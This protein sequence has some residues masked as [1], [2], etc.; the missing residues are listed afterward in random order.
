MTLQ[1]VCRIVVRRILRK[2]IQMEYPLLSPGASAK[3]RP[4][5][6]R[7]PR[8]CERR[9]RINFIPMQAGLMI[10]GQFPPM[11]SDEENAD[12]GLGTDDD[13]HNAVMS[14]GEGDRDNDS[15][16]SDPA[17]LRPMFWRSPPNFLR[18]D[19]A[20]EEDMA[21][22]VEPDEDREVRMENGVA[23]KDRE[24]Q[25]SDSDEE[26]GAA[27]AVDSP[28][29]DKV[30][31]NTASEAIVIQTSEPSS[32]NGYSASYSSSGIGTCSSL[33]AESESGNSTD[34][35]S[36]EDLPKNGTLAAAATRDTVFDDDAFGIDL[37]SVSALK[38][39]CQA[40]NNTEDHRSD[41]MED[42]VEVQEEPCTAAEAEEAECL[43]DEPVEPDA[44]SGITFKCCMQEKVNLLPVPA[45]LKDYLLYY[46]K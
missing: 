10:V 9:R 39:L 40:R 42:I 19:S 25:S 33:G 6:P 21:F 24:I 34:I 1:E 22:G 26:I 18:N 8:R 38:A 27:S 31:S 23:Y 12:H 30:V 4:P 14:D 15:S 43:Q 11:D 5:R 35:A 3:R 37:S 13:D 29:P 45:A 17:F 16:P 28:V 20:T 7:R 44:A 2:N 41:R 36:T 32:T 46:R